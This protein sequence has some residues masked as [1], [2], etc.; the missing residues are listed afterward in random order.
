MYDCGKIL[1]YSSSML[2]LLTTWITL[3]KKIPAKFG[4]SLFVI[5]YGLPHEIPKRRGVVEVPQVAELVH[6]DVI[7]KVS[8]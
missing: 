3:E 7:R 2:E 4:L 8:G 1:P 6:D 5:L